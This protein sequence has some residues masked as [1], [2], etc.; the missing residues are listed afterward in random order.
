MFLPIKSIT[1]IQAK[2]VATSEKKPHLETFAKLYYLNVS[3]F[4]A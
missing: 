1:H 2:L 3:S 4:T